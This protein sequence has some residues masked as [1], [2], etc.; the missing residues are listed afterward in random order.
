MVKPNESLQV[1]CAK[2]RGSD[3]ALRLHLGAHRRHNLSVSPQKILKTLSA[4]L[5]SDSAY[6]LH[7]SIRANHSRHP[8]PDDHYPAEKDETRRSRKNEKPSSFGLWFLLLSQFSRVINVPI[9]NKNDLVQTS[10]VPA[11]TPYLHSAHVSLRCFWIGS[12]VKYDIIE[13]G[14]CG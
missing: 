7:M 14:S 11:R 8:V 1:T 5:T 10:P 2:R 4:P 6:I 9:C 12:N 3:W 13:R